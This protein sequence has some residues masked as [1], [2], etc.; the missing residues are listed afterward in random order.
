[1]LYLED[2]P[3]QGAHQAFH[4]LTLNGGMRYAD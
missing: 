1:M 4:L 3:C 2:N